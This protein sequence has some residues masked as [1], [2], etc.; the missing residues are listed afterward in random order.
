MWG[1]K[2]PLLPE[3]DV[4]AIAQEISGETAKRESGGH[5]AVSP[6]ARVAGI[7]CR[8]GVGGGAGLRAYGLRDVEILEFPADGKIFYGTQSSRPAWDAQFAELWEIKDRV[9]VKLA[10][11]EVEPVVLAEDSESADVSADL[12]DV[13]ERTKESDYSGKDVKGKIVLVSAQ[14]GAVQDLAVGKFGAA[15]MVSY[16][17]NQKTAWSG[18]NQDAIRWGHLETFS[19]NKTFGFML[20]LKTA[21]EMKERL[22]KGEEEITLHAVVKAGQHAGKYE[23]VDSDD[24]GSGSEAEG[25]RD[26]LFLPPG[27]PASWGERQRERLRHDPGSGAHAAEID[28]RRKARAAGA[29]HAL[30]ISSG[31]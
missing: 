18:E 15:G 25:R 11:F 9:A 13:G 22:A 27:S 14:P 10:S 29:D 31:N 6:A 16:A 19:A 8:G 5:R 30:R 17:Q 7:S 1:Q 21:H 4:A 26:C 20:S 2:P 12:V 23:V 3:K 28:R 24:S